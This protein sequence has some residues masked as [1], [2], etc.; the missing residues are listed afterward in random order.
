MGTECGSCS[1]VAKK[2]HCI[3]HFTLWLEK[4]K[5]SPNPNILCIRGKQI[6]FTFSAERGTTCSSDWLQMPARLSLWGGDVV[7]FEYDHC[8]VS[9]RNLTKI[10]QH[11][12]LNSNCRSFRTSDSFNHTTPSRQGSTLAKYWKNFIVCILH[13][14]SRRNESNKL[15]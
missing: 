1:L 14:A 2:W 13:C 5:I 8:V 3:V 6:G 10:P 15:F 12:M 11:E 7:W 9:G 4:L